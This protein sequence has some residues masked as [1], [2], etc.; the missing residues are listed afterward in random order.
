MT[1]EEIKKLCKAIDM[2]QAE[3]ASRFPIPPATWYRY[4]KDPEGN[5][6][7]DRSQKLLDCTAEHCPKPQDIQASRA[8][9]SKT[10]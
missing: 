6:I 5:D 1:P 2:D 7:P 10:P 3:L 4:M 8:P 9:R